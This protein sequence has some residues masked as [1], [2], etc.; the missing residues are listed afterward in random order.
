[1]LFVQSSFQLKHGLLYGFPG[2]IDF[3]YVGAFDTGLLKG[4]AMMG[5]R[6]GLYHSGGALDLV[7]N[8]DQCLLLSLL[9]Q[10]EQLLSVLT[11][12]AQEF[13]EQSLN[14]LRIPP[15]NKCKPSRLKALLEGNGLSSASR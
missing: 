3:L 10:G 12:A 2:G 6:K 11:G 8:I 9:G 14:K 4:F 13:R 5:Q 1:M 7:R 15:V